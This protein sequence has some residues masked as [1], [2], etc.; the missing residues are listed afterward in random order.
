MSRFVPRLF[1]DLILRSGDFTEAVMVVRLRTFF[2]ASHSFA[3]RC[4]QLARVLLPRV[5]RFLFFVQGKLHIVNNIV[6]FVEMCDRI[7]NFRIFLRLHIDHWGLLTVL[8][9]VMEQL[10]IT[11]WRTLKFLSRNRATRNRLSCDR[12]PSRICIKRLTILP[13]HNSPVS[14]NSSSDEW[15]RSTPAELS[16]NVGDGRDQAAAV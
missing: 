2:A 5:K 7:F 6:R 4:Q 14:V 12:W 11:S 9:M 13:E 10:C 3:A 8:G 1:S 16:P 15:N